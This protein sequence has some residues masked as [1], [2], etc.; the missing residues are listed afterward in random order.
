MNKAT[1]RCRAPVVIHSESERAMIPRQ[2][3]HECRRITPDQSA[4][5]PWFVRISSLH[6]G[7]HDSSPPTD[8]GNTYALAFLSPRTLFLF[9]PFSL[10]LMPTGRRLKGAR[11]RER[12]G[13]GDE[14]TSGV[15]AKSQRRVTG[16]SSASLEGSHSPFCSSPSFLLLPSWIHGFPFLRGRLRRNGFCP[17]LSQYPR[18]GTRTRLVSDS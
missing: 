18:Q 3:A 11:E 4:F 14:R 8:L 1:T 13:A 10:R 16:P 5:R 15:R 2:Q 6:A 9:L 17:F 12:E 7:R